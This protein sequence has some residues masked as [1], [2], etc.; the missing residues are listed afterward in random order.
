MSLFASL[1]LIKDVSKEGMPGRRTPQPSAHLASFIKFEVPMP[2]SEDTNLVNFT[3]TIPR[4]K[5]KR[6]KSLSY[7]GFN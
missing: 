5:K 7:L 2:I 4:I 1:R 6:S 3:L